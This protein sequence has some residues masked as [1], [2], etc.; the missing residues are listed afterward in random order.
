MATKADRLRYDAFRHF[1]CIVSHLYFDRFEFYDVHHLVEGYRL[2]NQFT[3]PLNPWYHRGLCPDEL[4]MDGALEYYG[5]SMKLD[6]ESFV[7]RFGTER[8]LLGK[9]N[10]MVNVIRCGV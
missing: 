9:V 5:P 8:Y 3:I 2:G 7:K 1:G 10:E 6:K 4:T